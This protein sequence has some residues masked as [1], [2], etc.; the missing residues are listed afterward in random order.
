M[1]SPYCGSVAPGS[2][3]TRHAPDLEN[4]DCRGYC[5][6]LGSNLGRECSLGICGNAT[7]TY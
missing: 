2:S 1:F 4:K 6:V 7:S 3:C 5:E